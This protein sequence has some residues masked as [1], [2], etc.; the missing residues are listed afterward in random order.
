M[1]AI[2]PQYDY[3]LD[4]P[5]PRILVQALKEYG[6]LETPGTEDNP[7][8]IGWAQEIGRPVSLNYQHDSTPW[9][10]LFMAVCAK[11]A[12]LELPP[13]PLWA[14]SWSRWG[15]KVDVPKLGDVLTFKRSGGG[16]HVALYVGEDKT[17]FHILGGN[18]RDSVS[19]VR[20]AKIEN[21]LPALYSA[22]R[23]KWKIAEPPNIRRVF[24]TDSGI[25]AGSEA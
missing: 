3:L 15:V 20:K 4:E 10:G 25:M 22:N 6:T 14:L 11:R 17:H 2:E 9:C 5:S 12:G 24:L 7:K 13:A 1:I 16:G 18:Q 19:I 23:T 21:G 8:I